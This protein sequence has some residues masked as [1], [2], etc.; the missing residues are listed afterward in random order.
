MI[1]IVKLINYIFS[2]CSFIFFAIRA[3]EIHSLSKFPV[4]STVLLAGNLYP[5]VPCDVS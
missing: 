4:F 1:T 5:G 2:S 3:P